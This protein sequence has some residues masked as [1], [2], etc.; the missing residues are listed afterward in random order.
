L[1]TF[2]SEHTRS[3]LTGISLISAS[4]VIII[5]SFHIAI[6]YTSIIVLVCNTML[7]LI[8]LVTL[9]LG[10]KLLMYENVRLISLDDLRKRVLKQEWKKRNLRYPALIYLCGIDGSGKTTQ[11]NLIKT[12]LNHTRLKYKCLWL[13][14]AAFTS[15]PLL[16]VCRILGYTLWKANPRSDTK[17]PE[18]HFYRNR[19]V[20]KLWTWLFTIDMHLHSF[21]KVKLPLKTGHIVLCDRFIIDAIV[22]LI[23]ET[24]N[25]QLYKSF[26]GKLLLSLIPNG[27]TTVLIDLNEYEAYSRKKDIPSINY[28]A[29]RRKLYIELAK[30]LKIPIVNGQKSPTDLYIEITQRSLTH[31]PFWFMFQSEKSAQFSNIYEIFNNIT[32]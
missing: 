1:A 4:M 6:L 18:H 5:I 29:N 24:Q 8:S 30:H 13:R 22:D 20:A 26:I 16:A 27:S 3:K 11:T 21:L 2:I 7:I 19:A 9:M 28:L 15:Y 17:Y 14:W 10:F 25:Y 23:I 32:K 31:H 12:H